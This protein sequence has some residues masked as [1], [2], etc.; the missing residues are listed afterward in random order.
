MSA[1]LSRWSGDMRA[2]YDQVVS[3][4]T[5]IEKAEALANICGKAIKAEALIFARD[6][7][8]EHQRRRTAIPFKDP[9][10]VSTQ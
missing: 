6:V 3:G 8:E 10:V 4:E 2:L 1:E 9:A 5:T 7:F